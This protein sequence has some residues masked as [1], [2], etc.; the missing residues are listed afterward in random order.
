[1][2]CLSVNRLAP[3]TTTK[4]KAFMASAIHRVWQ[5]SMQA[6]TKSKTK[7]A[8]VKFRPTKTALFLATANL[9]TV[10]V[11]KTRLVTKVLLYAFSSIQFKAEPMAISTKTI[12]TVTT[13]Q[14][15]MRRT[16]IR[17]ILL[18]IGRLTTQMRL[19]PHHPR[20]QQ[21][22]HVL[23]RSLHPRRGNAPPAAAHRR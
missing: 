7:T 22:L 8:M 1:M 19:R 14:K 23:R 17:S 12:W 10:L 20:L 13:V 4:S 11:C 3:F 18:I 16:P 21:V 9:R 6:V 2:V 5:V 15:A